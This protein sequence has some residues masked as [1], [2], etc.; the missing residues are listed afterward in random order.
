MNEQVAGTAGTH[1]WDTEV[2]G[3][4]TTARAGS[5]VGKPLTRMSQYPYLETREEKR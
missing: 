2:T 4:A 1:I 5:H 3:P